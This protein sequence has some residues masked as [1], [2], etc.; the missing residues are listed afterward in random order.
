MT[1]T[2]YPVPPHNFLLSTFVF[3]QGD[4]EIRKSEGEKFWQVIR[5]N[6]NLVFAEV[7]FSGNIE[8]PSLKLRL[9]SKTHL[10]SAEKIEASRIVSSIL[11]LEDDLTPFY[12]SVG[13]DLP[14]YALVQ[15]LRGLKAPTTPTLFEALVDSIIEQ[16]ISLNVARGLESK[17]VRMFGD[18]LVFRHHTFYAFPHSRKAG[19]RYL[20]A[21][22]SLWAVCPERGVYSKYGRK[23]C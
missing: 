1:L 14:M 10:S 3:S 18:P 4:P 16:Q 23:I 20:E 9:S 11:N 22:P 12:Q 7:T 17:L 6:R 15:R 13:N 21:V 5:I 8:K 2:L 19:C